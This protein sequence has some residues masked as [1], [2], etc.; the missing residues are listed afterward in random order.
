MTLK[1]LPEKFY[2]DL[3]KADYIKELQEFVDDDNNNTLIAIDLVDIYNIAKNGSE[4]VG[5]IAQ[6]IDN[7]DTDLDIKY[8]KD[9]EPTD[10]IF[11]IIS[12]DDLTLATINKLLAKLKQKHPNIQMIFG[13]TNN[14]KY[15]NKIKIQ[16][17]LTTHNE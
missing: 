5:T 13:I 2:N 3:V 6:V 17:I 14:K 8:I 1:D 10:C 7:A 12:D 9:I 15:K 4:L 11:H 16:A